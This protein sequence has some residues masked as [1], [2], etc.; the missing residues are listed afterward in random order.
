MLLEIGGNQ[1]WQMLNEE[2]A[3]HPK[4]NREPAPAANLFWSNL[5]TC[6]YSWSYGKNMLT[7]AFR[8]GVKKNPQICGSF[9]SLMLLFFNFILLKYSWSECCVKFC[10][11]AKW[12]SYAYTHTHILFHVL[13]HCGLSQDFEYTSCRSLLFIHPIYN[14]WHLLILNSQTIPPHNSVTQVCSGSF[15]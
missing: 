14:S 5:Y 13:F 12:L 2:P 8:I 4:W 15:S 10:Y 9:S 6:L 1:T 11:T 7:T 3:A